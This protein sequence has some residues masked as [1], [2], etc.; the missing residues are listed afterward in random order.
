MRRTEMFGSGNGYD[1]CICVHAEMNA[2]RPLRARHR[3]RRCYCV[4]DPPALLYLRQ[5]D[6]P[7]GN[8][9]RA[10]RHLSSRLV[11]P[12]R[13]TPTVDLRSI[14]PGSLGQLHAVHIKN[15]ATER[16]TCKSLIDAVSQ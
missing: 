5:R 3:A 6:D 9:R 2:I 10:L 14:R 16:S 12:D 11:L 13:Q 1:K 8:L 4:R 7:G 15:F